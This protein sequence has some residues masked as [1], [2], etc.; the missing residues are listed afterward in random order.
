[1]M[2]VNAKTTAMGHRLYVKKNI[3]S[4]LKTPKKPHFLIFAVEGSAPTA[5]WGHTMEGYDTERALLGGLG[6]QKDSVALW[7]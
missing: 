3:K 2:G 6:W 4:P 7:G 5:R 1:M